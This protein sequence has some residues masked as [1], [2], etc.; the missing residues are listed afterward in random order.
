[1]VSTDRGFT[2]VELIVAMAISEIVL[3]ALSAFFLYSLSSFKRCD[4]ENEIVQNARYALDSISR[5]V[6]TSRIQ[7]APT[8]KGDFGALYLGKSA[9]D[10]DTIVIKCGEFGGRRVLKR[11][12]VRGGA[13]VNSRKIIDN[14]EEIVFSYDS[15][16]G[17]LSITL[18]VAAEEGA[19]FTLS[20]MVFSRIG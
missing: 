16:S 14:A 15:S 1:M 2:L 10:G 18:T 12:V 13:V 17:M 11:T 3:F 6:R 9:S 8:G 4:A 7:A 5:E 20:T 19:R